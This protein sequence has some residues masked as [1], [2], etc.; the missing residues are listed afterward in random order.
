MKKRVR[1]TTRR[2]SEMRAGDLKPYAS[3]HALGMMS[4]I[5]LVF[6]G[7][8]VWFSNYD[9]SFIIAKYP[10]AFSFYDWTFL[11]G[12]IQSYVMFYVLGW[13]FSKLYNSV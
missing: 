3:G 9:P 6:Y 10:I 13:V 8:F 5:I 12:L 11:F 2:V 7:L 4:M 1:H